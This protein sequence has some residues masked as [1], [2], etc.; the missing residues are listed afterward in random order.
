VLLHCEQLQPTP[1]TFSQ[2]PLIVELSY[3]DRLLRNM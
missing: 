2:L 3:K 1:R